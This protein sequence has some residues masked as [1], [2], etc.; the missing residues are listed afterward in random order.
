MALKPEARLAK[1][2]Q[3]THWFAPPVR[4]VGG[5]DR[6]A[7]VDEARAA[8]LELHTVHDQLERQVVA[9]L[10]SSVVDWVEPVPSTRFQ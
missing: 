1:A 2:R 6:V 4:P 9:A 8:R 3:I 5:E 10:S 7:A